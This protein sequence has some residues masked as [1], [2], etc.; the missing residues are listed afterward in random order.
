MLPCLFV[1]VCVC[2]CVCVCA[3]VCVD[4]TMY[5]IG[6]NKLSVM[7]HGVGEKLLQPKVLLLVLVIAEI[8]GKNSIPYLSTTLTPKRSNPTP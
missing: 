6:N 1:R 3:C 2:V 5:E 8:K 7:L 4:V